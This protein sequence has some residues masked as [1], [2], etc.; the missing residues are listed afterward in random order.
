MY[1]GFMMIFTAMSG[2]GTVIAV[3]TAIYIYRRQKKIAFFERW[4]KI[5]NDFENFIFDILPN[6]DWDGSA[7][8]VEKYS[9]KEI[10]ALFNEEYVNLQKD[11]LQTANTCNT[12][13]GNIEHAKKHGSCHNKTE[14]ELEEEK[15]TCQNELGE[16]FRK[17]YG[18]AYKKWL[19]I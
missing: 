3:F 4:T 8:L 15:I 13:I 19:T 6:W 1:N 11:I 9:A 12:L 16:R 5:L 10:A 2:I 18:E 14:T 17:K 7:K